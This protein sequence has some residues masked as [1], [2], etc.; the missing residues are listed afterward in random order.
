MFMWPLWSIHSGSTLMVEETKGAKKKIGAVRSSAIGETP[1]VEY[2]PLFFCPGRGVYHGTHAV[3]L[4]KILVTRADPVEREAWPP[5][6]RG[7]VGIG[8][9]LLPRGRHRERPGNQDR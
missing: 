6:K 2:T 3:A 1:F 4:P 7:I 5:V 8:G 9:L